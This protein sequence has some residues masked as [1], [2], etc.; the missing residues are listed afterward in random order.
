MP[1]TNDLYYAWLR[2]QLGLPGTNP[3]SVNDLEQLFYTNPNY[4]VAG[5]RRYA[6]NKYYAIDTPGGNT[7][8]AAPVLNDL[9]VFPFTVGKTQSFDRIA[10]AVT[11]AATAASGSVMRL[12]LYDTASNGDPQNLLANMAPTSTETT[13]TKEGAIAVQLTPGIYWLGC[14]IQVSIAALALRG[15][16]AAWSPYVSFDDPANNASGCGYIAP[17]VNGALPSP[18]PT[19]HANAGIFSGSCHRVMLRAA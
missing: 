3:L 13:G 15:V 16:G 9:N 18:F 8:I 4:G 19:S 11:T 5:N 6:F 17:G 12:G 10:L 1:S 2:N 7:T 14:V